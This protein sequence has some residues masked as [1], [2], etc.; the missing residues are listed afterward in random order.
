MVISIEPALYFDDIGGFRHSDTVLV[1]KTG[2]EIM[3]HYPVDLDSL[4]VKEDRRFKKAK[5]AIIR[6]FINIK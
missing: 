2:Y 4:T 1:T 5:G 3:T 6:K